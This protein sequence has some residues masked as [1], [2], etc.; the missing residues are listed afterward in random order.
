MFGNNP[1]DVDYQK[2]Y[3][4]LEEAGALY[5]AKDPKDI[6]SKCM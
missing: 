3:Q 4:E 6:I 1:T 5:I 2:A